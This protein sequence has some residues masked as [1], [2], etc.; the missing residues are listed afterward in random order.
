MGDEDRGPS[1]HDLAQVIEDLV[2]G[3]GVDAGQGVVEHQNARVAYDRAGDCRALLLAAGER[4]PALAD[5]GRVLLGKASI[6]VAMRAIS[7]ARRISFF[8]G[9]VGAKGD[10]FPDGRAEKKSF[11]RDEADV[12]AKVFQRELA[13]RPSVDQH[14]ARLGVVN[15]R[16]EAHQGRLAAT[17][18]AD[19][20]Q[21]AAC[22]NLQ[23]DVFE[24][25]RCPLRQA[26]P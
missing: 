16:N 23:V 24:N 5:G 7:A 25:G 2:L 18:G 19:N 3:L 6:S 9:V 21:A 13:D 22:R 14:H 8:A 26:P 11:L 1:L 20:R 12:A 10:V 17:R 15:A 4:Q